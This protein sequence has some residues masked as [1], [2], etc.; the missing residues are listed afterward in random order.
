M[1][2]YFPD[3]TRKEIKVLV[4]SGAQANL[5]QKGVA[6]GHPVKTTTTPLRLVANGQEVRETRR[7][8]LTSC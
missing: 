4:D 5:L 7:W 1:E 3:H 6:P 2:A 8:R